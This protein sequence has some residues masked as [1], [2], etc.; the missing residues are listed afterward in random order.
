VTKVEAL[1]KE[2]KKLDRTALGAFRDWFLRYDSAAWD[3]QIRNDSRAGK[4]KTM[5]TDA[6]SSYKSGKTRAL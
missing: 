4:L 6:L 3:E 5:A 1:E 2:V